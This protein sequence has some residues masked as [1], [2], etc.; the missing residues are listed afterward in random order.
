MPVKTPGF[1]QQNFVHFFCIIKHKQHCM[2]TYISHF[3]TIFGS[4]QRAEGPHNGLHVQ[5]TFCQKFCHKSKLL[6]GSILLHR[7]F[8]SF[9]IIERQIAPMFHQILHTSSSV[10]RTPKEKYNPLALLIKLVTLGNP[11]TLQEG[12]TLLLY[13]RQIAKDP[14]FR[15]GEAL[16]LMMDV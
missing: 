10:S 8:A 4:P 16:L 13:K 5:H 15:N 14:S 7:Q 11:T 2:F 6:N 12:T 3:K 1:T 9:P